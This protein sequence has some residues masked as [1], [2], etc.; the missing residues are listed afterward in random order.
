M[1][2]VKWFKSLSI[3]SKILII[4]GIILTIANLAINIWS[5]N[6]TSTMQK[7]T[8]AVI[9]TAIE[10]AQEFESESPEVGNLISN[11]LTDLM[12]YLFNL[13]AIIVIALSLKFS[14]FIGDI[15]NYVKEIVIS[16]WELL[17]SKVERFQDGWVPIIAS[18]YDIIN[19]AFLIYTLICIARL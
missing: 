6:I 2:I 16:S 11:M 18:I 9:N 14:D 19:I 8:Q 4:L 1:N 5:D 17:S 15:L 12:P 13:I 3:Y 10:A 7:S